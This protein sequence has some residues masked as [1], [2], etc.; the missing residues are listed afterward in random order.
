MPLILLMGPS[1]VGKTEVI[2]A[3]AKKDVRFEYVR[4]WT[5]RHLRPGEADKK[6]VTTEELAAAETAGHFLT[7]THVFGTSY[8]T[9]IQPI[10]SSLEANRF[11]TLDWPIARI[12]VME[13][14]FPFRLLRCYVL[15][16]DDQVLALRLTGREGAEAR[17]QEGVE[18]LRA[19]RGG[20]YADHIDLLVTNEDGMVD[21][22]AETIRFEVLART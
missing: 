11:P 15:P 7:V 4:P 8:G 3:L 14:A 18:E 17:L 13:A 1:G 19:V 22:V 20:A 16:P 10:T 9:P 12:G 6:H 2:H 21:L 5:T